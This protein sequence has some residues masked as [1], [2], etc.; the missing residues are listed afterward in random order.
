M[1]IFFVISGYTIFSQLFQEGYG[2]KKFL[3]VRLTRL[4]LPYFPILV[5]P[6]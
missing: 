3:M 4:S 2:L 6:I 5:W 1:Q